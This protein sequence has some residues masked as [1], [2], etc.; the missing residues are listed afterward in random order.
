MSQDYIFLLSS[1]S[2]CSGA[3][4]PLAI[5]AGRLNNGQAHPELQHLVGSFTSQTFKERWYDGEG[6][7]ELPSALLYLAQLLFVN[8]ISGES[9]M[10]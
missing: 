5:P 8:R 9:K 10:C 4:A 3:P 7:P 1:S 6:K 2:S